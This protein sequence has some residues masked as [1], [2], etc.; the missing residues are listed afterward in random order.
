MQIPSL[1]KKTRRI[2][3]FFNV[4]LLSVLIFN[5]SFVGVFFAVPEE[6]KAAEPPLGSISGCKW[7]DADGDGFWD[8][9]GTSTAD[10]L[11][12]WEIVLSGDVSTTTVTN[13]FGCYI[14]DNL[15]AGNYIVAETQK[16]GWTETFP[17]NIVYPNQDDPTKH[18]V[19]LQAGQNIS[20]LH[21]GNR[22]AE[23][24]SSSITVC[25]YEDA[26]GIALSTYDR[27]LSDSIWEYTLSGGADKIQTT[28]N[29]CTA[30]TGLEAGNYTVT[31]TLLS[32]WSFLVPDNGIRTVNL[33]NAENKFIAFVNHK[34]EPVPPA[35]KGSIKV[36]K[37]KDADGSAS[38]TDDRTLADNVW[39]YTLNGDT[40]T[41]VRSTVDGCA[42]FDGLTAG[43]YTI[44]E[45]LLS[46]WSYVEP[47]NGIMAAKLLK[48]ENKT[49]NF[50]NYKEEGNGGGGGGGNGGGGGGD[51]TGSI[52]VCKYEDKDGLAS[53]TD[54]RILSD[55]IWEYIIHDGTAT[56][57]ISTIDGC[58]TFDELPAGNYTITETLL[59]GW[60]FVDPAD[61]KITVNLEECEDKT[62]KFVNFREPEGSIKVCKYEDADGSASTTGDRATTTAVWQFTL[63]GGTV[64]TT[65]QSTVNG[66]TVFGGLPEGDYTITETLP[67]GWSYV[68]PADGMAI[69]N[70]KTDKK[71]H[72][73][74]DKTVDF[75]NYKQ[76]ASNGGGGGNGGGNGGGGIPIFEIKNFQNVN[77][78]CDFLIFSWLTSKPA[79]SRLIYDTV[80]HSDIGTSTAPNFGYAFST[81]QD[82]E[83]VT[84]HEES[85]I[86]LDIGK[87]YYVRP[88]SVNNSSIIFGPE[89]SVNTLSSDTCVR[90]EEGEPILSITKKID[91]VFARPGDKNIK[92]T[93]TVR[94]T[95]N[96]TAFNAVMTDTLPSGLSFVDNGTS[97]KTFML[98]DLA[99]GAS[100]EI[101]ISANIDR[102]AATGVYVNRAEARADNHEPVRTTADL[103]VRT[104]LPETGFGFDE[105]IALSAIMISLGTI[106]LYLG[107]KTQAV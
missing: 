74:E 57:A 54:D 51:K 37:Y 99:P 85:I 15:A 9:T 63:S 94:N 18:V 53:T 42:T 102:S 79:A 35:P 44:T 5:M 43:D 93:V 101:I 95:G 50:V 100:R 2:R 92:F 67:S 22:Q 59:F 21:F 49:V 103:E 83:E 38:T 82:S 7:N 107:R 68:D 8:E 91:R 80:S 4:F 84:G 16:P 60:S 40:A 36:C 86:G 70:I 105:L 52:K 48:G 88:V 71:E 69:V 72:K 90:G 17:N 12:G 6:A 34:E 26:D 19:N 20:S 97:S 10:I 24:I 29:G 46:G 76:P 96:L 106:G 61:G 23:T 30:F 58:A 3:R 62:V 14:F 65:T 28:E 27:V 41:T 45:T 81:T 56:T 104:T 89:I 25:K 55:S 47:A 66:C 64:A 13:D 31:E 77:S 32:G 75:V 73:S 87:T 78:G 1:S 11:P 33:G 98:G 39:E